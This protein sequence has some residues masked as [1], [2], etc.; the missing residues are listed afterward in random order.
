MLVHAGFTYFDKQENLISGPPMLKLNNVSGVP[1]E[2]VA[3]HF[4]AI[5]NKRVTQV[6]EVTANFTFNQIISA[7]RCGAFLLL[8]FCKIF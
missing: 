8:M 7:E 2:L 1:R 6:P 4:M 3:F 5:L